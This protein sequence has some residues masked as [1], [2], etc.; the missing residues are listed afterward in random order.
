MTSLHD[1]K[2]VNV[3]NE[4]VTNDQTLIILYGKHIIYV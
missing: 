2:N 3:N 4:I 1:Y